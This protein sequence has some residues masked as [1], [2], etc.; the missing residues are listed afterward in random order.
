M[1]QFLKN[2][3]FQNKYKILGLFFF[4]QFTLI[5][6]D[7]SKNLEI[8]PAKTLFELFQKKDSLHIIKPIKNS[9]FFS[10]SSDWFSAS[11]WIF[12]WWSSP[13]HFQRQARIR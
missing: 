3:Y 4:I 10:Y 2:N 8:C 1:I 13:I 6:E 9:F 5:A 11:N 12:F 7:N